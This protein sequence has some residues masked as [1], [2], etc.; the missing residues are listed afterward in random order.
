MAINYE[1]K[2]SFE[3]KIM[4]NYCPESIYN[5]KCVS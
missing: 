4:K 3:L 2:D 5:Y 1:S